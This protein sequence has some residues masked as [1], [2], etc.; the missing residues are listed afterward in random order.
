MR[1]SPALALATSLVVIFAAP[2]AARGWGATGHRIIGRLAIQSLPAELPDF[3]RSGAAQEAIGELAREP[4]RWKDSGLAHDAGRDPAHY[5]DLGDDGRVFGGPLLAELPATRA[6]YETALRAVGSDSWH[7]GYL[8]Y[9]IVDGWQQLTK[10]LAYWR[11]ETAAARKVEDRA[12]RAWMAAD[13]RRRKNLILR[14][15]GVLAHYVGDGSQPMHVSAHFNGWGPGPNPEGF[16]QSHVHA[17]F[18]GAFVRN[19]IDADIV[20]PQM[21]PYEEHSGAIAQRAAAYL[22]ATNAE[23]IPYYRLQKSGGFQEGDARGRTFAAR[24]LAAGAAELRDE[25]VDAWR[26]SSRM[27]VGYPGIRLADVLAGKVDPYDSLYGLD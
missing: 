17:Y 22:A 11:V 6:D 5:L 14:D 27:A 20:R 3:L 15:L 25:I 13:A 23:V 1:V 16:T 4:D 9:A 8:P 18:E 7:A 26:A 12:H 2:H 21:K 19:D 24:R 10:D